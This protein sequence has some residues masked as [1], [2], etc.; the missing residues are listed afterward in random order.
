MRTILAIS[1]LTTASLAAQS[2]PTALSAASA[3]LDPKEYTADW[4][5]KTRPRDPYADQQGRVWFVGQ[6]GNYVARLDPA[7]G[8]IRKFEI[9]AGTNPHNLVV[10]T[11]GTVWFTG[12]RNNRIVKM[13]PETGKLTT[14]MIPDP[15]VNDP[16]TMIFDKKG[17]A[18]FTAQNSGFVGRFTP[19]TGAFKLFKMAQGSK[20]YGIV[21]DSRGRPFFDLFGTN[22]IGTIDP[23][24]LEFKEFVL[25]DARTKPR[26]IA[27]SS[28][29]AIWY[30]DYTRGYLGRLDPRTGH[31]EEYP[32][33]SGGL[34]L[35]YGMTIDDR[36][37]VWIAETGVQ[38]NKLVSFD[39][40]KRIFVESIAIGKAEPNTIRHMMF[41]PKTRMIW[42]GEDQGMI[43]SIKVPVVI[44]P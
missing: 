4:L 32:M 42:F 19:S 26:R 37:H 10:D 21:L 43:G 5:P 7:S 35:P 38:P 24:T 15:A 33:P 1:L 22:K 3:K 20:P 31:T 44:T 23:A 41:D 30:G 27:I 16:H 39:T 11:K 28:D 36:D 14:Y 40:K 9:D 8:A 13:D 25:P 17:D 6:E 34:S 2:R 18:W 29:D 12:N